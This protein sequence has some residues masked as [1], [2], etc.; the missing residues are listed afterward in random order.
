MKIEC[1][2]NMPGFQFYATKTS[3]KIDEN[4]KD[5]NAF[6]LE[7]QYYPNSP[8]CASYPPTLL[9]ACEKREDTIIYKFLRETI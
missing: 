8:N 5:Y 7:P 2:S 9:K 1:Y 6:C 3:G 4:T